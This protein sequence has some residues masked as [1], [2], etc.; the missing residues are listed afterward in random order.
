MQLMIASDSKQGFIFKM[1]YGTEAI[2]CLQALCTSTIKAKLSPILSL[3]RIILI[4]AYP[5]DDDYISQPLIHNK[6][7]AYLSA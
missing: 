1:K 2:G 5:F 3:K 7:I 4:D 6:H